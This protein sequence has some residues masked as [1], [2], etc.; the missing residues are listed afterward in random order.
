MDWSNETTVETAGGAEKPD[1][2]TPC[3][4]SLSSVIAIAHAG[5]QT[6]PMACYEAGRRAEREEGGEIGRQVERLVA[7]VEAARGRETTWREQLIA[8][9][10]ERDA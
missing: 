3:P 5:T 2:Q 7:E 4:P 1:P 8:A 9:E 6:L 10:K